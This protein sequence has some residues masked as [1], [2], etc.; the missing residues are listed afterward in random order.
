METLPNL[1]CRSCRALQLLQTDPLVAKI[2]FDPAENEPS[3]I[4]VTGIPVQAPPVSVYPKRSRGRIA[5]LEMVV[6][7]RGV[8]SPVG[9]APVLPRKLLLQPRHAVHGRVTDRVSHVRLVVHA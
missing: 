6:R 2:G 4:W 5:P 1:A 7:L 8:R 3:K 9:E